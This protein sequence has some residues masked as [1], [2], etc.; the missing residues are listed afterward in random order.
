MLTHAHAHTHTHTHTH[1]SHT[2]AL[3]VLFA[4]VHDGTHGLY[5]TA[6][7]ATAFG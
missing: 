2:L 7:T 4:M 3:V 5:Y 1:T 6:V